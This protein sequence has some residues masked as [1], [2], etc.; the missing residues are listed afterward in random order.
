MH[1]LLRS[2]LLPLVFATALAGPAAHGQLLLS[3][4]VTGMFTDSSS[5]NTTVYNAPDGSYNSFTSGDPYY[6]GDPATMIEFWKQSFT[7]IG[8]G[9]VAD[10]LFKV[11]NGLNLRG[12][13]ADAAHFQLTINITDPEASNHLLAIPFTITNTPDLPNAPVDDTYT[14]TA[15]TIAPF[16]LDGYRVQF[17]FDAPDSFSV[18]ERDSTYVGSLWVRFTPVPEASTFALAGAALMIGLIGYRTVS[19]R[20]TP[21]DRAAA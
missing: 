4:N 9:L 13:T 14:I 21:A 12:S 2:H 17:I 6:G 3:G 1:P 20:K 19:R 16:I 7:D 8:P 18:A 11:T 15:G 5:G 10:D